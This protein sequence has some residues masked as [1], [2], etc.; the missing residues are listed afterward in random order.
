M[1]S[2]CQVT[3]LRANWE[4]AFLELALS[5]CLICWALTLGTVRAL[6]LPLLAIASRCWFVNLQ[7]ACNGKPF[8]VS[9][10]KTHHQVVKYFVESSFNLLVF[11]MF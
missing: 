5:T 11:V 9:L 7:A 6:V 3:D 2:T 8:R 1:N 10:H 4:C